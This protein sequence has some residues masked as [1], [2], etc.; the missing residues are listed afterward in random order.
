MSFNMENETNKK[1]QLG[2]VTKSLRHRTVLDTDGMQFLGRGRTS[3]LGLV[4]WLVS[5]KDAGSTPRFGSP[6]SSKIVIYGQS[7]DYPA[8]FMKH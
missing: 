6:F 5:G 8:Q 4:V 7:R 2:Y 1:L 3:Q